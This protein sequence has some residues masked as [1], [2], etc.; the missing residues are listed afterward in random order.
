[1]SQLGCNSKLLWHEIFFQIVDIISVKQEKVGIILCKN[2]HLIHT[3]LLEIFY[4]YMQQYNNT[5]SH[6][7]IKF[8]IITEHLSFLPTPIIN[9]CQ[10]LKIGR[11][12]KQDYITITNSNAI[13]NKKA[14]DDNERHDFINRV[15]DHK[16]KMIIS[17]NSNSNIEN[18]FNS[19]EIDGIMNIKDTRYFDKIEDQ[20]DLPKEVFNIVCDNIIQDMESKKKLNF[21]EFRDTLYEI[22]T[23]NLDAIEC[24]SYI[25]QYFIETNRFNKKDISDVL[26]KTY[27]FLKYYNNNYR[28][29]YHLESIMFYIINKI[30]KHDEL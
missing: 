22:L 19:I 13:P 11:P 17:S 28:P 23:Y 12:R 14:I 9:A 4:S 5:Q 15:L 27:V 3:E 26:E 18:L 6:I 16:P 29:I 21:T 20:N 25:V 8:F 10:I 24:L 2:F 30:H 1:M 7:Q